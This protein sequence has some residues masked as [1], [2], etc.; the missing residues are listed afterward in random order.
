MV[1]ELQARF[2]EETN[3]Y[4]S[5]RLE[6]VGASIYFGFPNLKVHAKL[7]SI[8][9]RENNRTVYYSCVSTGNFHEGNSAVY[10]D[11]MLLTA[12]KRITSEVKSYLN[13][14]NILIATRATNICWYRLFTC[15]GGFIGSSIMK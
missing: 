4:W 12:D 10:S 2:D 14:S 5:R 11:L 8:A 13:F 3:I 1:I 9:R 6:E 15:D 7:V